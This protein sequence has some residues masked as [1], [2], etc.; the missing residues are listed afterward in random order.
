VI[1][2]RFF[3]R[4]RQTDFFLQKTTTLCPGRIG[5]HDPKLQSPRWQA[6]TL[7]LDHAA[8]AS[9]EKIDHMHAVQDFSTLYSCTKKALCPV[10]TRLHVPMY[11]RKTYIYKNLQ[12]PE[13][14]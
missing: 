10:H 5:S 9:Q 6:E 3:A 14:G 12:D 1:S 7:P 13:T 8:G 11:L 4:V 2:Y